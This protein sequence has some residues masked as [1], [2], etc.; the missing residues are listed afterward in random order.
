MEQKSQNPPTQKRQQKGHLRQTIF[1]FEIA[2]KSIV[3]LQ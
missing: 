1:I 3:V 2:L